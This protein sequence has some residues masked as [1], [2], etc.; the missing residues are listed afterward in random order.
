MAKMTKKIFIVVTLALLIPL[1]G[2][3]LKEGMLIAGDKSDMILI[4]TG[5]FI[6][7][8]GEKQRIETTASFYIDKFEVSNADYKKFIA[9][10]K[11][12]S[13][14]SVRHPKQ[15]A[16]KDHTPRHWKKFRPN[17]LKETGIAKLQ[18]FDDNTFT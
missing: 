11:K 12:N 8:T 13:D 1:L 9:W 16:N 5:K 14:K 18:R 4:P 6:M 7:G 17:L 3:G 10:V 15:P 2:T